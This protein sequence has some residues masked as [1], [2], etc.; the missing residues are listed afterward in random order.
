MFFSF[1]TQLVLGSFQNLPIELHK[2][3]LDYVSN[4][5]SHCDNILPYRTTT[6]YF[7]VITDQCLIQYFT[8]RY[9]KFPFLYT[10]DKNF[11]SACYPKF[12]ESIN[13]KQNDN[14]HACSTQNG[15]CVFHSIHPSQHKAQ[16]RYTTDTELSNQIRTFLP[17]YPYKK[18]LLKDILVECFMGNTQF[19][20]LR[21][22]IDCI[23]EEKKIFPPDVFLDVLLQLGP[24]YDFNM[25]RYNRGAFFS[26]IKK[27]SDRH[28]ILSYIKEFFLR[29]SN[30]KKTSYTL[31][32]KTF[33]QEKV[34]KLWKLLKAPISNNKDKNLC[35]ILFCS[36]IADDDSLIEQSMQIKKEKVLLLDLFMS[37]DENN[38]QKNLFM[39]EIIENIAESLCC[40]SEFRKL[41]FDLYE[42]KPL[43]IHLCFYLLQIMVDRCRNKNFF[44]KFQRKIYNFNKTKL[45]TFDIG[46][47]YHDLAKLYESKNLTF[48]RL[49]LLRLI[50][51]SKA[52]KH[53][54]VQHVKEYIKNIDDVDNQ[55]YLHAPLF[56]HMAKLKFGT[57]YLKSIINCC[58]ERLKSNQSVEK[59]VLSYIALFAA[60]NIIANQKNKIASL[61]NLAEAYPVCFQLLPDFDMF[62]CFFDDKQYQNITKNDISRFLKLA[63]KTDYFEWRYRNRVITNE[64]RGFITYIYE[65]E[66]QFYKDLYNFFSMIDGDADLLLEWISGAIH[67]DSI[68]K[69]SY[70]HFLL[71]QW[72]ADKP[73]KSQILSLLL[74]SL[75]KQNPSLYKLFL[76]FLLP[77]I[78]AGFRSK[79]FCIH[80]PAKFFISICPEHLMS[81]L[82]FYLKK[83]NQIEMYLPM[84]CSLNKE[85]L[86]DLFNFIYEKDRK[87]Y[88]NLYGMCCK[89]AIEKN[90]RIKTLS[91]VMASNP[92]F[93]Y[94]FNQYGQ[95]YLEKLFEVWQ[96]LPSNESGFDNTWELQILDEKYKKQLL[97]NTK[98]LFNFCPETMDKTLVYLQFFL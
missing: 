63:I 40:S 50:H 67:Q 58:E 96:P 13:F 2:H 32:L 22:T 26:Y 91:A 61:L 4:H 90:Y 85:S 20:V 30:L 8:D 41:F 74:D 86:N 23:F 56:L 93:I 82:Q 11:D 76:C 53:G 5:G 33:S 43:P 21:D 80:W 16:K 27:N 97:F 15:D 24:C 28:Y 77:P 70:W 49:H 69:E 57:D 29:Y 36:L 55:T 18:I 48:L 73:N 60:E 64:G 95:S 7:F 6:S 31:K 39:K 65:K 10:E 14:Y 84:L 98:F 89:L 75:Q 9:K 78:G 94:Y 92:I 59:S 81:A 51:I 19:K 72:F 25:N 1:F 38:Q 66:Q 44:I 68:E 71:F 54:I 45:E 42:N 17:T 34:Q 12:L 83:V 52:G 79:T 88:I 87:F 37:Q 3:I 46:Q 35:K 47:Y 62:D